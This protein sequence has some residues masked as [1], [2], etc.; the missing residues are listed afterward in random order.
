MPL[1]S[2]ERTIMPEGTDVPESHNVTGRMTV[3][4]KL[5]VPP[6]GRTATVPATKSSKAKSGVPLSSLTVMLVS[7][8]PPQLVTV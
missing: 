5:A 3:W 4:L 2:V 8:V 1:G 7:V 6:G